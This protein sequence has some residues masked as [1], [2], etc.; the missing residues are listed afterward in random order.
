MSI[1]HAIVLG[2]T[3]GLSEFLPIS[4]SG[5]LILV[6]WLFRWEEFTGDADFNK[7]FDVALHIGTF[8]GALTY[9][10]ADIAKYARAAWT[11]LRSRSVETTDQR[12]GWLLLA[13]AIPAAIIGATLE[14]PIQEHT[15]RPWLI[16]L[17]LIVFGVVL[18]AADRLLGKRDADEF[19]LRD[20]LFMGMAQAVAL[21]PGVSRSGAT[22]SMGRRM[23]FSREAAARLSFLMAMPITGGAGLYKG[24]KELVLGDGIP[25][26]TGAAFLWGMLAAAITGWVAVYLVLRIVRT[27]SFLPFVLY[28]VAAGAAVIV[29]AATSWR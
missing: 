21:Q 24:F 20:A 29:I 4:S 7:T 6:P 14:D 13:S 22:I 28:R 3:Q 9:F 18:L 10:R 8:I 5:H 27:K 17:M 15:G 25:A 1:F 2:I 19:Q 23:G 16:G 26:G 12:V 11:S